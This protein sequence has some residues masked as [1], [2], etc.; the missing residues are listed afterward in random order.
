MN[1]LLND[2]GLQNALREKNLKAFADRF[3]GL[4]VKLH[5]SADK[6]I[7]E[8]DNVF[9]AFEAKNGEITASYRDVLLHSRY[10][11]SSEA[12]KLLHTDFTAKADSIVFFGSG[13]GYGADEAARSF[14]SKNLIVIE[15]DPLRLL[16]AFSFFDWESVFKVRS[17]VFLLQADIQTVIAVLEH[18]G[19][20]ESALI[21]AKAWTAHA[22]E[23]FSALGTLIARNRDKQDINERTLEKFG[24]LWLSNM[25]K[26]LAESVKLKSINRYKDGTSTLPFCILAAGPS[27]D[28]ILPY[29]E[30]I[31]K[32]AVLVC[33]DTALRSC[34][35]V[36]VQPHFII[37]TDPQYLNACHIADLKAPESILI[38]E[39]AV[40]P[41]VLR[42]DCREI[43]LYASLFPLGRYIEECTEK[44]EALAAGG[45]VASSAWDFARFCGAKTIYTAGLD[46][47][48]PA[49]K[50]H[51]RGSTFEERAHIISNRLKSGEMQNTT[52]VYANPAY[53]Q[54]KKACDY[55][56][57]SLITDER[58]L[59]YAWW[60][61]SKC[62][63][64][65]N[66]K[67]VSL[68]PAA[69]H[70]PGFLLADTDELLALPEREKEIK[71]FCF[72]PKKDKADSP[73]DARA[74]NIKALKTLEADLTELQ[75]T[76]QNAA[77]LCTRRCRTEAD[78]AEV[79]HELTRSDERI[80]A[81]RVKNLASLIFPPPARLEA[82]AAKSLPS[83][84][85]APPQGDYKTAAAYNILKSKLIYDMILQSVDT[86]IKYLKKNGLFI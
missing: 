59:L 84:P 19:L 9:H 26:N 50:T 33:T 78:Y 61:E 46:L 34:L 55:E 67:T 24:P 42:F 77:A 69:L 22:Q 41:G 82:I 4:A 44:R 47:S 28:E 6:D 79:L 31:K 74:R 52:A 70:I 75:H 10:N 2:I 76:V 64:F 53:N 83:Q 7:R 71:A 27:L 63:A 17:C 29:L 48:Y 51:A 72:L 14:P 15:P 73:R 66:V 45:S 43:I 20:R 65:P 8:A 18:Y 16:Q 49:N 11:P 1:L 35:R 37:V 56:G 86:H 32:R 80:Y 36:G 57:N 39:I 5:S 68:S 58:M 85:P 21:S 38:T 3:P 81:S 54:D 30:K 25:C 12:A 13:L 23:Y 40:Y 62:A 60:F